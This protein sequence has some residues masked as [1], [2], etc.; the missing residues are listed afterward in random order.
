MEA[1][2]VGEY[3]MMDSLPD[4][5]KGFISAIDVRILRTYVRDEIRLPGYANR[6]DPDKWRP[7]IMSF[8]QLYG[9]KQ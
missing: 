3:V 7:M 9:L 5:V 4:K 1:E 6:I 2:M 8:E